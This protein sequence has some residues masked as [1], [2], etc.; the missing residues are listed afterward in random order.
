[1]QFDDLKKKIFRAAAIYI[2]DDFVDVATAQ[3]SVRGIK[4]NFLQRY[5]LLRSM[6]DLSRQECKDQLDFILERA[7]KKDMPERVAVNIITHD[8]VLRRFSFN[9]VPD[10]ELAKVVSF[11]A[12][13]YIPYPIDGMVHN[14][15]K[16]TKDKG[17]QEVLFAGTQAKD[18]NDVQKYFEDKDILASVIV[19][20]ASLIATLLNV[21]SQ[22]NKDKAYVSVH[23]DPT[24]KVTITGIS[25]NQPSFFRDI[26]IVSGEDEFKTT[27]LRYPLLDDIWGALD[28]EIFNAVEYLKRSS[29]A[30]VDKIFVSGFLDA[31]NEGVLKER[32]GI[33]I[34]RVSFVHFKLR[35]V[36]T[37][38]RYLPV[39]SLLYQA[40]HKPFLNLASR[41]RYLCV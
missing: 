28:S 25:K 41:A 4:V 35:D 27:E 20:R 6:S 10:A 30:Q 18:V 5:P 21:E 34:E 17:V 38:D 7:F 13:K 26:D 14:F 31:G 2:C 8:F 11:E 36:K 12:Q 22:L 39:F 23:F 37:P 16:C 19:P 15:E 9:E 33:P 3:L 40:F 1:M 29:K 24:N 32:F